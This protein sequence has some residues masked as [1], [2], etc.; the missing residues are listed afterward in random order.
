MW[1]EKST[2]WS[3]SK[4][5]FQGNRSSIDLVATEGSCGQTWINGVKTSKRYTKQSKQEASTTEN[6]DIPV[7][8]SNQKTVE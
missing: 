1:K 8:L 7:S 3:P 2:A 6:N 4:P 5:A